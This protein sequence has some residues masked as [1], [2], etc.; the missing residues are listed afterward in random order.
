MASSIALGASQ[1]LPLDRPT[2]FKLVLR[3]HNNQSIIDNILKVNDL[4]L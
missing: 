3:A 4:D 1:P 2:I